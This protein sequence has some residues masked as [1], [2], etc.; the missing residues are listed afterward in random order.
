MLTQGIE[1]M[2]YVRASAGRSGI[3]VMFEDINQPRHDGRTIY[4]PKISSC[5]SDLE[6]KEM[7][8]SVDHEVAHDRF[9]SFEV[10]KEK[11]IDPKG[12]L[13]YVWNFLEDSRVNNIEANEYRGFRENWDESSSIL[14][15][16]IFA[17][18]SK[19]DSLIAK[20]TTALIHWE[21]HIS[22]SSFPKIQLVSSKQVP[23]KEITNVLNNYSDRL[24]RCHQILDKRLGTESTYDLAVDIL[25]DLSEECKELVKKQSA[26][27][28]GKE[29]SRDETEAKLSASSKEPED[30]S[31]PPESSDKEGK[32]KSKDEEYKI[33]DIVLNEDD[34]KKYSVTLPDDENESEMGKVGVNFEPLTRDKDDWTL[35]DYEKFV[36][37]DYPNKVGNIQYF[38]RSPS[39]IKEHQNVIGDK[40]VAQENFGQQVRRLIQIRAKVQRQYGVKKGKLDQSRLSRICFN[41]PGFSERIF[42]NKIENKILDAAITVLVDMSGSMMGE[43]AH[44]ALA[45]TLLVNEVCSTLNIPVEIVGFTDSGY[46]PLMFIYKG[47]SDLKVNQDNIIEYFACSSRFMTGNPDGENILW[48]HNRLVKRKERKKLLIVMSDGSP[49]A[50]KGIHGLG[51]FT[52]QV[53]REIE[54]S[55]KVDIY[56]LGLCSRAVTYYYKAN[57]IVHEPEDIPNKLI[58]LIERKLI[59]V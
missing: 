43:K 27:S 7:M 32:G 2:K 20:L 37:V 55:K 8:A 59:N 6:L 11:E 10:L 29:L 34:I 42:K 40:V 44:Y 5:T 45:S 12:I 4:L 39:F 15:D 56:G 35:T 58:E 36:V 53:I 48:A 28:E 47:F 23:D 16:S 26:K 21:S 14:I 46:F 41:A 54:D 51:E 18:A 31:S 17:K 49:A 30:K 52:H 24:I 57:S 22:A 19:D 1:V 9:S 50:T 13:L 25:K 3:S 33:Y 38:N